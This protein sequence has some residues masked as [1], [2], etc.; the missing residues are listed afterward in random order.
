[1]SA[2][3]ARVSGGK[4]FAKSSITGLRIF[5]FI[6]PVHRQDTIHHTPFL[7]DR[8][9]AWEQYRFDKRTNVLTERKMF[10]NERSGK[11]ERTLKNFGIP[12]RIARQGNR[13]FIVMSAGI[14]RACLISMIK[15]GI[16][17]ARA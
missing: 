11:D 15:T 1:M 13:P 16:I 2:A 4:I 6:W 17:G 12:N 3:S 10:L 9:G 5:I 14:S 8:I 7:I